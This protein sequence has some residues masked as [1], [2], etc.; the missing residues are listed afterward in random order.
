MIILSSLQANSDSFIQTMVSSFHVVSNLL[1]VF[2]LAT[3]VAQRSWK[4]EVIIIIII[5]IINIWSQK[6][7]PQSFCIICY[8]YYYYYYYYYYLD[9]VLA[10]K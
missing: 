10:H 4:V 7:S 5:I 2:I 6:R 8:N 3:D 9:V 1:F